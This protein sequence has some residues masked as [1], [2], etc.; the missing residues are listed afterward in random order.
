MSLIKCL[1]TYVTVKFIPNNG[2]GQLIIEMENKNLSDE[3]Y[4]KIEI[5]DNFQKYP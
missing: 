4:K 5:K 3:F 2:E 1:N